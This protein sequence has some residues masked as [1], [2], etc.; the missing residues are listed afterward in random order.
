MILLLLSDLFGPYTGAFY[1]QLLKVEELLVFYLLRR[2]WTETTEKI[3]DG[4]GDIVW[5]SETFRRG[6]IGFDNTWKQEMVV[7]ND[8]DGDGKD[9]NVDDVDLLSNNIDSTSNTNQRSQNQ[10]KYQAMCDLSWVKRT[11]TICCFSATYFFNDYICIFWLATRC[12]KTVSQKFYTLSYLLGIT[13]EYPKALF[14]FKVYVS[15]LDAA[16]KGDKNI[17]G[18]ESG[19]FELFK[20][21]ASMSKLEVLLFFIT[22]GVATCY[23]HGTHVRAVGRF[24]MGLCSK[25][26]KSVGTGKEKEEGTVGGNIEADNIQ[27]VA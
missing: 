9:D 2:F 13:L 16:T 11:F 26:D 10:K 25:S 18:G 27:L 24:I 3:L 21:G 14:R 23:V 7:S 12:N 1:Y 6:L 22:T 20:N 4:E 15:I 17:N 19:I 8:I 5:L